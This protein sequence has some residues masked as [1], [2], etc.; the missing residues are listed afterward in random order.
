[1]DD[2][3]LASG[4]YTVPSTVGG[5]LAYNPFMRV[6]EPAVVAAAQG[7]GGAKGRDPAAVMAALREMKNS[8]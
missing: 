6:Q 2:R 7:K 1:M 5:E 4:G 8:F 3:T